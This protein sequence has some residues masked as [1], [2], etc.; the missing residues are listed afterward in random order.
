MKRWRTSKDAH[1]METSANC[2]GRW[3]MPLCLLAE[4]P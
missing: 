2:A 1:G 3:S 4:G